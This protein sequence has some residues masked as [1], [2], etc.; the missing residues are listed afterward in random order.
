MQQFEFGEQFGIGKD[1]ERDFINAYSRF[2]PTL[3]TD[4]RWDIILWNGAK[5]EL[6]TDT[7]RMNES[8]NYFL[9]QFTVSYGQRKIAGPWRAKEDC[10]DYFVYYFY[11]DATFFWFDPK[12]LCPVIDSYL[13]NSPMDYKYISNGTY[14]ALGYPIARQAFDAVLMK[15]HF[16]KELDVEHQRLM[17]EARRKAVLKLSVS[18]K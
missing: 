5:V 18:S 7:Y 14:Y 8:P 1:G 6:K 2:Q 10:A 11:K 3:S 9:E 17:K 12:T 16:V 13:V 15:K 4:R